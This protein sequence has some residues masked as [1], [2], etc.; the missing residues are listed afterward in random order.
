MDPV[1]EV[2][3]ISDT[4]FGPSAPEEPDSEKFA[5]MDDDGNVLGWRTLYGLGNGDE[6]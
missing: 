2:L 6:S 1:V 5:I 4:Q 3:N